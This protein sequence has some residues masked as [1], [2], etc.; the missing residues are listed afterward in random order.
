[1]ALRVLFDVN[2]LLDRFLARGAAAGVTRAVDALLR[3]LCRRDDLSVSITPFAASAAAAQWLSETTPLLAAG[4]A[5]TLV[6]F[7]FR[8]PARWLRALARASYP[9]PDL[10]GSDRDV[11]A[12]ISGGA[13]LCRRRRARLAR[14]ILKRLAQPRPYPDAFD[15]WFSP[16]PA[17]PPAGVCPSATRFLLVHDVIP[18]RAPQFF[19]P[20]HAVRMRQVL[21]SVRAGRDLV[22]APSESTRRDV[23]LEKG[24]PPEDVAVVPLAADRTLFRP[25]E[26]A[27]ERAA[28][29]ARHG[30]PDGPYVIT[31]A[32]LEP[33]KN[34]DRVVRAF[35]AVC[36]AMGA[37]GDTSR[38]TA[39]RPIAP[40]LVLVGARGWI[41]ERIFDAVQSASHRDRIVLAGRV[42]DPDLAPLLSGARVFCYPSLY[43][44]FGLPVLEAMQCGAPVVTSTT[45]SLPEV[46]GDAA[47]LVDPTDLRALT[48]ALGAVL[49]DDALAQRLRVAGLARAAAFSWER[50]AEGVAKVLHAGCA[51]QAPASPHRAGS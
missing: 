47:L 24:V 48:E 23:C 12:R 9:G 14:S 25:I 2:V 13:H 33:R 27:D 38:D 3:A 30:I 31:L 36:D 34:L 46:A 18:L 41:E 32:T 7:T 6:P 10:P 37:A 29:R 43:E 15:A 45:S 5:D 8:G 28:A 11:P 19:G 4:S 40:A 26:G 22:L 17:L 51:R 49:A 42:P 21:D 50:T 16:L 1:M 20:E 39:R 44:G 35:D